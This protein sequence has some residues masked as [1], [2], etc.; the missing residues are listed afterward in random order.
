[1]DILRKRF[2]GIEVVKA[3][4]HEEKV[5]EE[6]EEVNQ[7]LREVGLKAQIWSGF[8]MPI[9]NVINNFGFAVVAVMGGILAVKGMITIGA[10]ASFITYSRQFVRPLNDLAKFS[11]CCSPVLLVRSEFLKLSMSKRSQM[12][13][14]MQLR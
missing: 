11:T 4:N 5:I 2:L 7:K 1:M 3:F 13:C 9:M 8:L 10:I 6:F 12:I 14:R